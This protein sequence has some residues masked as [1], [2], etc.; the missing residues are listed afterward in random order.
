VSAA[1]R[2][3]PARLQIAQQQLEA[4]HREISRETQTSFSN[5]RANHLRIDSTQQEVAALEQTVRAQERGVELGVVRVVDLLD[6]RR[7][8]VKARG[9]H[10]RARYDLVRSVVDLKS[11]SGDL[12]DDDIAGWDR[13][14]GPV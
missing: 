9:D 2:E 10:A 4:A 6:A 7:R 8:L 3:A 12:S 13:W 5:A 1:I 14:F 11:R